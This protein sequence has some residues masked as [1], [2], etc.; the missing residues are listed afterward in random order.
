MR[1]HRRLMTDTDVSASVL[2]TQ[3]LSE[4]K[5][6]DRDEMLFKRLVEEA[7]ALVDN[8]MLS[9]WLRVNVLG[10]QS[11]PECVAKTVSRKMAR[12]VVDTRMPLAQ[13]ELVIKDGLQDDPRPG[14]DI[15]ATMART[16]C[17]V[18][19]SPGPCQDQR[20]A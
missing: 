8:E 5:W 18:P 9:D 10:S 14:A 11:F 19:F 4:L 2:G 7:L 16:S 17:R 20:L 15:V 12:D 1:F 3:F 6:R 13:L